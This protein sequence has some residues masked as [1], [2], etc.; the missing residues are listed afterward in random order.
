MWLTVAEVTDLYFAQDPLPPL[1]WRPRANC[2]QCGRPM[3]RRGTCPRCWP[4]GRYGNATCQLCVEP[5]EL[6]SIA[7]RFHR[8]CAARGRGS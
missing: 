1:R 2:P 5:M 4:R 3:G 7:Q 8:D 6:N